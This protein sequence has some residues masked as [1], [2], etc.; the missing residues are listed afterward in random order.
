MCSPPGLSEAPLGGRR[1][2]RRS[3]P[4]LARL[5]PSPGG[6]PSVICS[7][8]SVSASAFGSCNG[9]HTPLYRADGS[10]P[11]DQ[12]PNQAACCHSSAAEHLHASLH[13]LLL[14]QHMPYNHIILAHCP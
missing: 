9:G 1:L 7:G 2:S 4:C 6:F 12:A 10:Q 11:P 13:A 5:H 3:R 8:A 14:L